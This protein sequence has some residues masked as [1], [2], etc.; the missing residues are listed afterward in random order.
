MIVALDGHM[1]GTRETGNET[2]ALELALALGRLEAQD[3]YSYALY[4]GEAGAMRA[5]SREA[6]RLSVRRV[7]GV[8]SPVRIP[9]T[10][11]RL[12]R[13]D[14]AGL[15][16]MQYVA[17]PLSPCPVVLTV[18]DVSHRIYP[19][20]FSAKVRLVVAPLTR[21]SI[22]RAAH[23]IASSECTARDLAR[24]YGV[25]RSRLTVVPLAA[26]CRFSPQTEGEIERVR[27][28]YDLPASYVLSVA[29]VEP[30]KNL[31][32]LIDAFAAIAAQVRDTQLVIAGSRTEHGVELERHAQRLGLG[33]RVRFT[34][35]VEERDLPAMYSG[36]AVF[37]YPSLYE[38][39]GLPPLEA[40]GCGVPT[41]T[42]DV[43][44]LPEVVGDAALKVDPESVDRLASALL[45]LLSDSGM[46][47][48][49]RRRGRERAAS[50]SWQ[51]TA[52][53]TK[54]VYDRVLASAVTQM[55]GGPEQSMARIPIGLGGRR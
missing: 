9:W 18:H 1:I 39:F 25:P 35:Y 33:Q 10:Y 38:G 29:S 41:V 40:L 24:Y 31:A 20:F 48:E 28:A 6:P 46:R 34:G 17:P 21:V 2:Y 45:R 44:S 36:A 53:M 52:E 37:C 54:G 11:P 49:Y 47:D 42:A 5:K 32:R 27:K 12:A 3:G 55:A 43:S 16:H 15:L 4:T 7:P 26:N 8:P 14:G 13:R 22:R 30:R 19:R 50:F 51:R 23:V